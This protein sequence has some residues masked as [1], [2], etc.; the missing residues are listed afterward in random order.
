[1][2]DMVMSVIWM[3]TCLPNFVVEMRPGLH[4][5]WMSTAILRTGGKPLR[6]WFAPRAVRSL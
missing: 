1:M 6:C 3:S 4:C 2:S 5:G